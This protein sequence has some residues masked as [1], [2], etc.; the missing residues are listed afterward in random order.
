[1]PLFAQQNRSLFHADPH[2]GNLLFDIRTRQLV[3]LDWA[4][5]ERLTGE[6]QRHLALLVLAVSMRDCSAS[7]KQIEALSLPGARSAADRTVRSNTREFLQKLP[8]TRVPGTLDAMRLVERLAFQGITFPAA[9]IMLRKALFTLD[10]ILHEI[11]GGDYSL[12]LVLGSYLVRGW[13][14]GDKMPGS[15]LCITDWIEIQSSALFYSSR[16]WTHFA[17]SQAFPP[18]AATFNERCR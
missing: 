17:G 10:G 18:C 1:V 11:A 7:C 13:L 15:P 4:L 5:T 9:L 2:A 8:L 14:R 6:Q 3:L 12:D 16:W